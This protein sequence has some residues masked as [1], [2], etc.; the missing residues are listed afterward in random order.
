M[1]PKSKATITKMVEVYRETYPEKTPAE[2]LAA[3]R[4]A[5][6]SADNIFQTTSNYPEFLKEA[7]TLVSELLGL[8]MN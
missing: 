8:N 5:L 1:G 3:F 4:D 6:Q 2:V 7:N